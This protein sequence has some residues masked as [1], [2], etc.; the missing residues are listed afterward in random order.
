MNDIKLVVT[1]MD[2]T[3]LNSN[4]E[5]S[6]E[7]DRIY[8]ELQERDILFVPASGRQLSAITKYFPKHKNEMAFIAE[9]GAYVIHNNKEVFVDRLDI[10]LIKE[11]IE[12]ARTVEGANVILSAKDKAY[13]ESQNQN[14]VDYQAQFY[15]ENQYVEDLLKDIDPASFKIAIY[16]ENGSEDNLYPFFKHFEK[17][18]LKVVVSG[19]FWLDIMNNNINKG[20]ALSLLHK[21]LNINPE[22]TVAFGD[23]MNDLEMLESSG[24]SYAMENAHPKVK[25]I[26]KFSAPT[27]DEF[28]VIKVIKEVI[29][30]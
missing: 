18:N 13:Y 30:L 12:I 19:E 29:N 16:H 14:F 10:N 8:N 25:E 6:P 20:V 3:F 11:I 21:K 1:D 28:G 22:Q 2:G 9:N 23:Y 7:F 24:Y 15:T 26:A 27:N 17:D 4:H 5:I